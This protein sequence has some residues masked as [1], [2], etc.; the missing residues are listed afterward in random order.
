MCWYLGMA[1]ADLSAHYHAP[2]T[3][4][5]T[6]RMGDVQGLVA[7]APFYLFP[8]AVSLGTP[9]RQPAVSRSI[10]VPNSSSSAGSLPTASFPSWPHSSITQSHASTPPT[11]P[12]TPSDDCTSYD[13]EV[14][15][16][17]SGK[18]MAR[19]RW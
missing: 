12:D 18:D 17:A 2:Q 6:A 15:K 16:D 7:P 8:C 19:A 13:K 11:P 10:G 4:S 5:H 9:R 3:E 14:A 1:I